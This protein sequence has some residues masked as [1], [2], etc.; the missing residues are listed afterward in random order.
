MCV[1][2]TSTHGKLLWTDTLLRDTAMVV[3]V[4]TNMQIHLEKSWLPPLKFPLAEGTLCS[5]AQR[6]TNLQKHLHS[7]NHA[8][9]DASFIR[10]AYISV[11]PHVRIQPS[12]SIYIY[13]FNAHK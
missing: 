2:Y 5:P 12:L 6:P 3:M 7:R 4:Q 11:Y 1:V 10:W 9:L 8:R 13:G